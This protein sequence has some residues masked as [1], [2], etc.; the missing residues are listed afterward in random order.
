MD[1]DGDV[2]EREG[3]QKELLQFYFIFIRMNLFVVAK[4]GFQVVGEAFLS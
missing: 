2:D 1:D 3:G 4:L